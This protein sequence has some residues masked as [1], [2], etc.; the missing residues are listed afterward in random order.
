MTMEELGA[1]YRKTAEPIRARLKALRKA[2]S[3]SVDPDERWILKRQINDLT[4][5]LRD[6]NRLGEYCERYYESGFYI[7]DGP[8]GRRKRRRVSEAQKQG[9]SGSVKANNG[10]RI[11]RSAKTGGN[12]CPNRRATLESYSIYEWRKCFNGEQNLSPGDK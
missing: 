8:F 4:P 11:E 1:E 12:S 6:M 10:E 7:Q 3:E 5:I 2:L 9:K